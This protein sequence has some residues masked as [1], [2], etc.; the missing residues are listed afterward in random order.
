MKK[1]VLAAVTL[2]VASLGAVGSAPTA[3]ADPYV[4]WVPTNCRVKVDH[5]SCKTHVPRVLALVEVPS[6]RGRPLGTVK[7]VVKRQGEFVFRKSYATKTGD[8]RVF[9][10]PKWAKARKYSARIT[11][12][13]QAGTV[14][15]GCSKTRRFTP[16]K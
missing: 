3:S 10:L 1:I 2:L 15:V 13:P 4:A 8:T 12:T 11:F 16:D 6:S 5:H 14:Y 7:V 9:L